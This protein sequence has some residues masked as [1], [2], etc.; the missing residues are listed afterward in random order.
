MRLKYIKDIRHSIRY[1]GVNAI[2]TLPSLE[3][4]A[5][6]QGDVETKCELARRCLE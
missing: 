6:N 2:P 4:T 1:V 5:H 3:L